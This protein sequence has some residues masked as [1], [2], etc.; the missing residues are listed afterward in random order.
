VRSAHVVV[1]GQDLVDKGA[2]GAKMLQGHPIHMVIEDGKVARVLVDKDAPSIAVQL[3]ENVARQVLL[4][5]PKAGAFEREEETP[6]GTMKV[7]YE[8][9][10]RGYARTVTAASFIS[11]L[12]ARCEGSCALHAHAEGEAR[13]EDDGIVRL[14]EHKDLRAGVPNASPM[15]ETKASFE[16]TRVKE[17]EHEAAAVDPAAFATKAPFEPFENA[18]EKTAALKRR[19]EGASIED[20]LGGISTMATSGA[21]H[22]PKGWLVRSTALLELEPQ[23][24]TEVAARFEDEG[25]GAKG[26]TAILDLLASTG[27]DAAK[28]TLLEVLGR[29]SARKDDQRLAFVQRL[30]LVDEPNANLVKTVRERFGQSQAEGDAEMAYAEAHVLGAMAGRLAAK[31][32][33]AESKASVDALASSVDAAKIAPARSAYLAALGNAGD[34]GQVGRIAKHANDEDSNVRRAVASALRKTNDPAARATLLTLAKDKDEDV[35][36]TAV[37]S[38]S[39]NASTPA[40]Q[41]ELAQLLDTSG[42]GGQA[43]NQVV[44][45]LLR[46]GPPSPEVRSSLEHVL[47]RTEDPRLAARIRFALETAAN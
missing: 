3:T 9:K 21:E 44:T 1:S 37:D 38:L 22:L 29:D 24:L 36:V 7:H 16:A 40:E 17:G 34:K 41:H 10:G 6:A 32:Q 28:A 39:R 18:A 4:Q 25:I 30:M 35:Q 42:L 2:E 33:N 5:R 11:G 23:L 19:A 14:T 13:F 31:G 12:P 47:A 45:T 26:R 20:V 8:P 46:Q 15:F 27:G 43:E